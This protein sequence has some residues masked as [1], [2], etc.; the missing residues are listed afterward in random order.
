[1]GLPRFCLE[2]KLEEIAK[3]RKDPSIKQLDPEYAKAIN[4]YTLEK[5]SLYSLLNG[6][7]LFA[8]FFFF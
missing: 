5:P 7:R 1:M 4:A 6:A 8:V 3:K 2:E